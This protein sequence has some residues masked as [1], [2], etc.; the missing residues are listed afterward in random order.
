MIVPTL[1][2]VTQSRMLC[3]HGAP[4]RSVEVCMPTRSLGTISNDQ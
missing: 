2:V 3:V 4:T 1:R